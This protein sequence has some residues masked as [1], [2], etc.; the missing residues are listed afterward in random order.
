MPVPAIAQ[1]ISA[2]ATPVSWANRRGSEKTPGADHR[3]DDHRGHRGQGQLGRAPTYRVEPSSA[4]VKWRPPRPEA[5]PGPSSGRARVRLTLA[6]PVEPRRVPPFRVRPA[7]ACR[8]RPPALLNHADQCPHDDDVEDD[9]GESPR[10]GSTGGRR[11]SRS[12]RGRRSGPTSQAHPD[13]SGCRCRSPVPIRPNT[14]WI[15][16]HVVMSKANT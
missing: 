7:A 14:R 2:P 16:P 13:G 4:F 1:A 8:D 12:S 10:S 6:G 9:D 15:H 5:E 11:S 3:A